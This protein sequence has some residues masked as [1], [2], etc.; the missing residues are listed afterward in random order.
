M[1][2]DRELALQF[3]H[4]YQMTP[5]FEKD[6]D[7]WRES[8][9]SFRLVA[10]EADMLY[11]AQM[12]AMRILSHHRWEMENEARAFWDKFQNIWLLIVVVLAGILF[13]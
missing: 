3:A 4:E 7:E 13:S 9:P 8:H 5:D 6:V 10:V 1:N 12:E 2:N 11:R